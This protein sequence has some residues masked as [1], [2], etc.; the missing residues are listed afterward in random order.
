L[1]RIGILG[2]IRPLS[3]DLTSVEAGNA[4]RVIPTQD[5]V[6]ERPVEHR[7][8]GRSDGSSPRDR[9][10]IT[11]TVAGVLTFV[12]F[13]IPYLKRDLPNEGQRVTLADD[14]NPDPD[15]DAVRHW[16]H[17][18]YD[19]PHPRELRWWPTRSLDELHRDQLMA[20]KDA[21][22]DDPALLDYAEQLEKDGPPRVCRLRFRTKNEVGGQVTH[23][24]LFIVRGSRI[25][26]VKSDSSEAHAMLK[27]FPDDTG[28]P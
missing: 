26:P 24:G 2:R 23:D 5:N 25:R 11:L 10:V 7:R 21:A 16:L 22:E 6:G 15:R 19:D 17:A 9:L 14:L 1:A 13:G 20:A 18:N 4:M 3:G 8:R 12:L 27:Y 28:E